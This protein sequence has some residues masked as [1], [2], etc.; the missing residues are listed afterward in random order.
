M[1]AGRDACILPKVETKIDADVT[2]KMDTRQLP[3]KEMIQVHAKM[4]DKQARQSTKAAFRS[5]QENEAQKLDD[6]RKNSWDVVQRWDELL[7]KF[8][9]IR[10]GIKELSCV[11]FGWKEN[12]VNDGAVINAYLRTGADERAERVL[13]VPQIRD[14]I[15]H[16]PQ[17]YQS[18]L[19]RKKIV[20]LLEDLNQQRLALMHCSDKVMEKRESIDTSL[21][22]LR[23]QLMELSNVVH[24]C[25]ESGG[26]KEQLDQM[27]QLNENVAKLE[28]SFEKSIEVEELD[29]SSGAIIH[30]I[31][32]MDAILNEEEECIQQV[33]LEEN[34]IQTY[35]KYCIFIVYSS[36]HF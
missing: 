4:L 6:L 28:L 16:H 33:K 18:E 10:E 8:P 3:T 36:Y 35:K 13:A 19:R 1:L 34:Y 5:F 11:E 7:D 26:T 14:M 31:V 29:A 23:L 15:K 20:K 2:N 17:A 12:L 22:P 25:G 30:T 24:N 27:H 9:M 21:T 32:T